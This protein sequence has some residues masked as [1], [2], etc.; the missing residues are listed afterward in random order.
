MG[1]GTKVDQIATSF[2]IFQMFFHGLLAVLGLISTEAT[3]NMSVFAFTS[4]K[5]RK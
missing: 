1:S 3:I 2:L 5:E 4:R